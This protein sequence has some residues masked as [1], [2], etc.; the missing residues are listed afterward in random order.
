MIKWHSDD[1]VCDEASL[2]FLNNRVVTILYVCELAGTQSVLYHDSSSIKGGRGPPMRTSFLFLHTMAGQEE[3]LP[4]GVS[5]RPTPRPVCFLPGQEVSVKGW[6]ER[7]TQ[8]SPDRQG[9][10]TYRL[11]PSNS[12]KPA[13]ASRS[14]GKWGQKGKKKIM[15]LKSPVLSSPLFLHSARVLPWAALNY[16]SS[17]CLL[18]IFS[19]G[20]WRFALMN[21]CAGSP[22]TWLPLLAAPQEAAGDKNIKAVFISIR[23]SCYKNP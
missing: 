11:S 23:S 20:L 14:G 7:A 9:G 2:F 8:S 5:R 1:C 13:A 3:A 10:A 15:S 6:Q 12:A 16:S 22:F 19:F 17:G 18:L 4:W 21:I